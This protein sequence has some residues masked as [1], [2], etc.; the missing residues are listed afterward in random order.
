MENV[1]NRVNIRLVTS[2]H[3]ANKL[4]IKPNFDKNTIFCESLI[5]VYMK[6]T[7]LKLGKLI[8]LGASILDYSKTLMYDFHYDYVK[9][10]YGPKSKLLFTNTD[11]LCCEIETEV[12]ARIFLETWRNFSIRAI[13][14][15]IIRPKFLR[16]RTKKLSGCLKTRPEERLF[17]DLWD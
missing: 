2:R 6:K 11:S 1:R 9:K 17:R 14:Q 5:A 4:A 8:Y 12:S 16:E 7:Q 15:K 10:N 13:T 3:I